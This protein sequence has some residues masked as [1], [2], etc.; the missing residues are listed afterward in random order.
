MPLWAWSCPSLSLRSNSGV[1]YLFTQVPGEVDENQLKE[2][3]IRLRAV[4][5]VVKG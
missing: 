4:E 3:H 2:L 1:E 5:P